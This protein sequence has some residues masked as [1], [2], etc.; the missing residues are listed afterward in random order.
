MLK[1]FING[2]IRKQLNGLDQRVR[3]AETQ[4]DLALQRIKALEEVVFALKENVKEQKKDKSFAKA[5]KWLNGY[6]DESD[7]S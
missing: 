2:L 5:R 1:K 6:P 7:R 4:L 3:V